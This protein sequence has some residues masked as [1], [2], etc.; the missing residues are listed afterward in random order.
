MQCAGTSWSH[1]SAIA[2]GWG[3]FVFVLGMN[4][5]G[6]R[7]ESR[8]GI[9]LQEECKSSFWLLNR[10]VLCRCG[11]LRYFLSIHSSCGEEL[12]DRK[13]YC[14][15][16]IA[17]LLPTRLYFVSQEQKRR[18]GSAVRRLRFRVFLRGWVLV[19][20][21]LQAK[22]NKDSLTSTDVL[23]RSFNVSR[24]FTFDLDLIRAA[25]E[26]DPIFMA[27][28]QRATKYA[29]CEEKEVCLLIFDMRACKVTQ[30]PAIGIRSTRR[31]RGSLFQGDKR[32][33]YRHHRPTLSSHY[34]HRP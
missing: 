19:E 29:G 24:D 4:F 11:L 30:Y 7:A 26:T 16:P 22:M 9:D 3:E 28:W 32:C 13:R 25:A 12:S 6:A 34:N 1:K 31:L 27:V 23:E 15:I 18:K 17:T 5:E 10:I 2:I 21:R 33:T 14:R 8:G 20:A